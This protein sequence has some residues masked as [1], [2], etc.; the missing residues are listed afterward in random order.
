MFF[1]FSVGANIN[2]CSGELTLEQATYSCPC[3]KHGF[4]KLIPVHL[5]DW[6]CD[7]LIVI[8]NA[9]R[10]GNCTRLKQKGMSVGTMG[11]RGIKT[12]SPFPFPV[13]NVPSITLGS[14]LLM[15]NRVPLHRIG[16]F[17]LRSRIIGDPILSRSL[18]GGIPGVS[19]EFKNSVG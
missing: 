13:N 5:I 19:R 3:E 7:L 8:E 4:S 15:H 14:N 2:S 12:S 10:I 1:V 6:P 16:G 17:I 18:C 9:N 11:I